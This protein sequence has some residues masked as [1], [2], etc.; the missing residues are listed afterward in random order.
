MTKAQA[1]KM[2]P[3]LIIQF[4]K[5]DI[6]SSEN[7]N[8]MLKDTDDIIILAETLQTYKEIEIN[9]I[10]EQIQNVQ[11]NIKREQ[12]RLVEWQNKLALLKE[13]PVLTA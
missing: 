10:E 5:S 4:V 13:E 12:V 2:I 8:E 3:Q 11:E 6:F 9:Y 1:E 7:L